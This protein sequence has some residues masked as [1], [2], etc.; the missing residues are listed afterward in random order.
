MLRIQHQR[1][2]DNAMADQPVELNAATELFTRA[3]QRATVRQL[4]LVELFHTATQLLAMQQR[5]LVADLYKNWIA[6]N[7]E[8]G[9]LYAAYFNYGVGLNDMRDYAGAINAFRESI[10]LKPDF[11][12]AHI[13]LGRALEDVG[14]A[15]AAVSE[16]MKLVGKLSTVTGEAVSHK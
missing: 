9:L 15:G 16:W 3:V 10:R 4:P 5:A 8:D 2:R 7:A 11:Q 13:N 14:L 12:P 1:R 6:Y